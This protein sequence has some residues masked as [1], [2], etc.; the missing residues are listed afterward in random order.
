[1]LHTFKAAITCM[2][3]SATETRV[4]SGAC[5]GSREQRRSSSS[6]CVLEQTGTIVI[7][8]ASAAVTAVQQ[9]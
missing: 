3:Q 9:L 5:K 8:T 1:V 2:Q 7:Y 4:R 6:N